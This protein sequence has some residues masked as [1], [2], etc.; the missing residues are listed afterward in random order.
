MILSNKFNVLFSNILATRGRVYVRKRDYVQIARF[1][2]PAVGIVSRTFVHTQTS[3][4][5]TVLERR[6]GIF[7]DCTIPPCGNNLAT[8]VLSESSLQIRL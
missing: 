5:Q 2:T 3:R 6:T 8:S 1:T 7:D 4:M